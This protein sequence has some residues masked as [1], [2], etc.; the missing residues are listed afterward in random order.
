MLN[1]SWTSIF[2]EEELFKMRINAVTVF[3][4]C[5]SPQAVEASIELAKSLNAKD[6]DS[7]NYPLALELLREGNFNVVDALLA[8]EDPFKYFTKVQTGPYII[9]FALRTLDAYQPGAIYDKTLQVIFGI[10]YRIYHSPKE[11]Y[12]LYKLSLEHL[13]SIGKFLDKSKGQRDPINRFILDILADI[14][15]FKSINDEDPEVDR[16]AA[17]AINIRNAFFDRTLEM[18][19]IIPANLLVREDYRKTAVMPR[20]VVPFKV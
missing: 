10:L 5:Q 20:D 11:G 7:Q 19:E 18:S 14:G 8:D 17:H 12:Q 2:T 15:G 4:H 1:L 3:L 16:L 13:N 9:D 6:L